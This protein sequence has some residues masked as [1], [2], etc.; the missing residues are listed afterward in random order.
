VGADRCTLLRLSLYTGMAQQLHLL[1]AHARSTSDTVEVDSLQRE[2]ADAFSQ[3]L[4]LPSSTDIR[5]CW[6]EV[7]SFLDSARNVLVPQ[8]WGLAVLSSQVEPCI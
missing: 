6:V 5:N 4:C 8:D 7:T 1:G 3:Y 2:P